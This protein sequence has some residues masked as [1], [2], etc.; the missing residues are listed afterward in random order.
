VSLILPVAAV[1]EA[2]EDAEEEYVVSSL[3]EWR[4]NDEGER[5]VLVQWG[6]KWSHSRTWQP[7]ED[8]ERLQEDLLELYKKPAAQ[9][10]LK[11]PKNGKNKKR[12]K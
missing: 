2:E 11:E 10:S 6:G 8:V 3:V 7:V 1:I 5:E 9:W 12:K 4:I